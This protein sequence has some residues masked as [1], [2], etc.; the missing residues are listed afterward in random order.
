MMD[1]GLNHRNPRSYARRSMS[2]KEIIFSADLQERFC[3]H[4]KNCSFEV[5]YLV[6]GGDQ[7]IFPR[8]FLPKLFCR[9]NVQLSLNSRNN[10]Y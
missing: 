9:Q 4:L 10:E 7:P 5:N 2:E 1:A 6:W 3:S 8:C